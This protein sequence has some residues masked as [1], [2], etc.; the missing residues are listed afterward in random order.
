MSHPSFSAKERARIFA[1]RN[2]ICHLC[3]GAIDGV[4]E[5]W[6]VEHIIDWWTSRDNADANLAPA[7]VKCH[8]PKTAQDAAKRAKTK[9]VIARH[10]GA[11]R[12][13]GAIR[14]APKP[15][16]PIRDRLPMPPRQSLYRALWPAGTAEGD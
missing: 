6:D 9:R 12:P 7:H 14:S 1:M 8:A 2:G 5:A 4:R 11:V 16:K 3:G 15:E 13:K 10:T